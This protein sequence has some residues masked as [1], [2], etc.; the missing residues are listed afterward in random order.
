MKLVTTWD[1]RMTPL[2]VKEP[3]NE[4][5]VTYWHFQ[6]LHTGKTA[7][8]AGYEVEGGLELR[9]QYS[10][11]DVISTELFRGCECAEC[12]GCLRRAASAGF[13]REGVH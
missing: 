3:K 13:D 9:L 8:C 12:D 5:F 6:S 2:L 10:E 4:H 7:S 1:E 11:D